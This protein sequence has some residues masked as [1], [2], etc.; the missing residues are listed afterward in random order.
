MCIKTPFRAP[1]DITYAYIAN[2]RTAITLPIPETTRPMSILTPAMQQAIAEQRLIFAATVCPDGSPNLSP[3]GTA[4]VWDDSHILFADLASP[5]TMRNL[6]A[7]PAIEINIVS[8]FSRQ[9][10]RFKGTADIHKD[11]AIHAA[12]VARMRAGPPSLQDLADRVRAVALVKVE[13]A[14]P[15]VSPGYWNGASEPEMR[16]QWEAYWNAANADWHNSHNPSP[17]P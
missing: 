4:M 11:D 3:K 10:Y 2:R 9:G 16:R 6:A 8:V 15:L 7:N 5:G 17:A 1:F 13:Q 12:A 14:L